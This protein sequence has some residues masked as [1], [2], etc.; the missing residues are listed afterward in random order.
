MPLATALVGDRQNVHCPDVGCLSK[1]LNRGNEP[2]GP[3]V[4]LV[5]R[6]G[7]LVRGSPF[8]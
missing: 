1:V 6:L 2:L 5:L 3:R 7:L 8:L 4:Q